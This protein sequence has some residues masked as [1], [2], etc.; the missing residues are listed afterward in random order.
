MTQILKNIISNASV[1]MILSKIPYSFK[2]LIKKTDRLIDLFILRLKIFFNKKLKIVVGASNTQYQGWIGTNIDLLDITKY[3]DWHKLFRKKKITNILAEHVLE[4]LGKKDILR[5]LKNMYQFMTT[6]GNIRIAVPDANHPSKYVKDLVRPG[7]IE[8]G[9]DDHKV[10]LNYKEIIKIA[11]KCSLK[12]IPVEYF[13]DKGVFQQFES[14]DK[15]GYVKR[16][17]AY[18][19]G[20]FTNSKAEY[21]KM[22][23][24]VPVK[25]RKQFI[26]K[27]ISYTS[28][29]VDLVK[30]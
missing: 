19:R 15:N 1:K 10:F 21:K 18:Y 29:I 17:S 13:D 11:S 27:G 2:S 20:R 4:H 16:S 25:L 6:D 9:A 14:T 23:Q 26:D 28:L 22:I 7:G 5:A 30:K 3:E 8:P 12:T 24:A